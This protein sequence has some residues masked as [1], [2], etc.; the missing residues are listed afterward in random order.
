MWAN[1]THL[2]VKNFGD[3]RRTP[4]SYGNLRHSL[5]ILDKLLIFRAFQRKSVDFPPGKLYLFL[6]IKTQEAGLRHG[7]QRKERKNR[8]KWTR[9]SRCISSDLERGERRGG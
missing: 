9:E 6:K 7:A 4:S 8:Q 2:A 3:L 1:I 5:A